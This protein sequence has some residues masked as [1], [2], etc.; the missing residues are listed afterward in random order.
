MRVIS[1]IIQ[2]ANVGGYCSGCQKKYNPSQL[3]NVFRWDHEDSVKM[4]IYC[5]ECLEK[6]GLDITWVSEP[7]DPRMKD[8]G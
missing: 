3:I 6:M 7:E 2:Y 4:K 5:M 1:D 8:D